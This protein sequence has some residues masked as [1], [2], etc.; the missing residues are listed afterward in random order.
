M[1]KRSTANPPASPSLLNKWPWLVVLLVLLLVGFIRYRLV[2]MPLER[3]EGEYAYAGQ[4]LLQGIPPYQ[5]AWNMKLPGTYFA[6]AFG[7]AAFGQDSAGIHETLIVVN[8]L[9][10]ICVFVLARKLFGPIAG[11]AACATFGILSVSPAVMGMAAHANHFVILFAMWATLLLWRGEEFYRWYVYFFSGILYGL[12]FLMKQQGICFNLFAV[13]FVIGYAIVNR[14]V[15]STVF[16]RKVFYLCLGMIVPL[17]L[18][19]KYLDMAGVLGRCEF[20]TYTYAMSYATELGPREGLARFF[21]YVDKKWPIYFA[22][23]GFIAVSLPFVLRDRAYRNKILFAGWFLVFSFL[24]TAIDFNFREHYFI[25]L[26]PALAIFV[27]LAIVALQ[28]SIERPFFKAFPVLTCLLILGFSVYQQQ[29][30]FFQLPANTVSQLIYTGDAPFTVMPAV[31]D[32]IRTNSPP[33]ATVAVIGSEPEIYFYAQRHSATG[34]MYM[35]PL[36][37]PQPFASEM[38]HEMIG[39]IE[40]N[41]PQFLVYVANPDSW[42]VWPASD[43]TILK[44]FLQY[45]GTNYDRYRIFGPDGFDAT[46]RSQVKELIVVY[47][48]K[49]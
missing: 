20:W 36:M 18:T 26:L 43:K 48:R 10:I 12:A 1:D 8:A 14:T 5:L 21:G 11:L 7:M 30:Y 9:T 34:Y 24:G 17:A 2:D 25:L 49:P 31:G 19:Y 22:F 32:C 37:E 41:K 6:Y 27:G 15:F 28:S 46:D 42:T 33:S 3:D 39:E 44:W 13:T 47:Q 35:Y 16:F 29:A 45:S 38:Q 23:L 40:T 4:L